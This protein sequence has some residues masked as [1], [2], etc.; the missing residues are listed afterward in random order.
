V[1]PDVVRA[2][3]LPPSLAALFRDHAAYVHRAARHLGAPQ[4]EL[5]DVVQEVFLVAHRR[6]AEFEGRA[7]PRT[8]LYG[9]CLRVVANARRRAHRHREQPVARVPD[10]IAEPE[11]ERSADAARAR[12][13][14][15]AALTELDDTKRAVF[16]L[17][18][19]EE[20]AI[21]EVARIVEAPT[22]TVYSRLYA[23]RARVIE[24]MRSALAVPAGE[25]P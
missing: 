12:S 19:I 17:V 13:A 8:W 4:G 1:T 16:V 7:S 2:A 9:I 21:E 24:H 25:A 11:L 18:D 23:A 20:I 5:D 3:A 22:K 6:I 10:T 15:E 14:L